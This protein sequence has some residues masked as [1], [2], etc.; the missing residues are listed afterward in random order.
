MVNVKKEYITKQE[1]GHAINK[2][3]IQWIIVTVGALAIIFGVIA[4][5]KLFL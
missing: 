4:Y 2:F 5:A 1:V 3:V